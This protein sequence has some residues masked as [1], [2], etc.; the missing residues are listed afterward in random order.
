M[1]PHLPLAKS[2]GLRSQADEIS[3]QAFP[4]VCKEV[5]Q[6]GEDGAGAASISALTFDLGFLESSIPR[7]PEH[8][9][10]KEPRS[11]GWKGDRRGS[12]DWVAHWHLT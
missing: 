9:E 10:N 4:Q 1:T 3:K 8:R 12:W 2:Q 7:S 11:T 5:Q 6:S